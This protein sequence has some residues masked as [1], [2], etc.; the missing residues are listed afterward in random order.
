MNNEEE[1]HENKF[2]NTDIKKN[3]DNDNN[4]SNNV[5][6]SNDNGELEVNKKNRESYEKLMKDSSTNLDAYYDKNNMFVKILLFG[7]FVVIA[8]GSFVIISAYLATK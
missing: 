7:L 8:I 1:K 6:T 3:T 5:N 4:S 2:F